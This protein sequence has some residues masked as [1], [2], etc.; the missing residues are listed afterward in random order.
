M[1]LR[2]TTMAALSAALLAAHGC[3][4]R[5][6]PSAPPVAEPR[7][8]APA[9]TEEPAVHMETHIFNRPGI[10]SPAISFVPIDESKD[11]NPLQ[12]ILE[13]LFGVSWPPGS[14]VRYIGHELNQILARN[15]PDNLRLIEEAL[16]S[17]LWS[18]LR[19]IEIQ[20]E[21]VEYSMT[22][23]DALAREDKLSAD[24]LLALW[25]Q[26]K[27]K[28]LHAPR[29]IAQSGQD[30]AV[31][32]VTEYIYPTTFTI[33][34]SK[35]T[36]AAGTAVASGIVRP[37]SFETREVGAIL[38]VLP[39]ILTDGQ[40]I[41]LTMT[42]E[43]VRP[44]AW[45]DYGTVRP[46]PDGGK[47]ELRMEQPFFHS[48]TIM[49]QIMVSDGVR[50]LVGGGM[51]NETGDKT[52]YAFATARLLDA[53]GKPV[54]QHDPVRRQ[55]EAEAQRSAERLARAAA[56]DA[57][58]SL[59]LRSYRV[60]PVLRDRFNTIH[61]DSI[62]PREYLSIYARVGWPEGADARYSHVSSRLHVLNSR[63]NQRRVKKALADAG[64]ILAQVEIQA[65]FVEYRM[66]DVDALA[67]EN[68]L[69]PDH[70]L[71]LWKQ[72]RGVLRYA[73]RIVTQSG[74]EAIIRGA[75]EYIYPT[76]FD[77]ADTGVTNATDSSV[78]S[79]VVEPGSFETREVGML[80]AVV[81]NASADA[82]TIGLILTPE[83]VRPP[84]WKNYG[85]VRH[86]PDGGKHE[87]RME[88][89][90]FHTHT[91]TTQAVVSDGGRVMI[92]G[93]MKNKE[94]DRTV[95]VFLTARLIDPEGRPIAG[96]E[97]AEPA[98]ERQNHE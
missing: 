44:P 4:T 35:T 40:T 42:P 85:P 27:A 95:Y 52:V 34:C 48:H 24:S 93:G 65:D 77:I 36:N 43:I 51:N 5:P 10:T 89:P 14:H 23:I 17:L 86:A 63:A 37:S 56:A 57:D 76:A 62:S 28:L 26:G 64:L 12:L 80:F 97:T 55:M 98:A 59:E 25:R 72:G 74:Q 3:A 70:L 66:E 49:T 81:A 11:P 31:K 33:A 20:I 6:D 83:T 54:R 18:P 15:T 61:G 68:K 87:W 94:G 38:A 78:V 30:S 46:A 90:F 58:N 45:K 47:M 21:F 84:A 9:A 19:Q 79:G 16:E 75:T 71:A 7:A 53:D 32:G 39:D 2:R 82:R 60:Y 92:G 88:Q 22:D 73:P 1:T 13:D 96:N 91:L 67:R 41:T 50:I 69:D 29:I 8:P